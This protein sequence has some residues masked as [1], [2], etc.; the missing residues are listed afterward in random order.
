MYSER[1]SLNIV[2]KEPSLMADNYLLNEATLGQKIR[3][4]NFGEGLVA[5]LDEKFV[6]V[7]RKE[8]GSRPGEKSA[9]AVIDNTE[10]RPYLTGGAYIV[11]HDA[12]GVTYYYQQDNEYISLDKQLKAANM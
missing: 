5:K 1:I 8:M 4:F 7:N 11:Y 9:I 10:F 3:L 2:L 12:G 6:L